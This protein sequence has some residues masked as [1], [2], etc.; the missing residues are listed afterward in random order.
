MKWSE[1]KKA[2]K[3]HHSHK[4]EPKYDIDECLSIVEMYFDQWSQEDDCWYGTDTYDI[5]VY[6]PE[7][8][9]VHIIVYPLEW[10]ADGY[11]SVDT[12]YKLDQFFI[13]IKGETK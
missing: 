2:V 12:G 13:T 10:D 7:D 1:I 4:I 11:K 9:E 5:N 3:D 6:T 8:G